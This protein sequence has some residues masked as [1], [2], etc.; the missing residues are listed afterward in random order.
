M[1]RFTDPSLNHD[2]RRLSHIK[3]EDK[4]NHGSSKIAA[5]MNKKTVRKSDKKTSDKTR[6]K[7]D[8]SQFKT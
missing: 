8:R 7:Q 1:D 3:A 2:S 6:E 5:K 4:K